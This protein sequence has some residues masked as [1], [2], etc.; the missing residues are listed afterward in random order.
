MPCTSHLPASVVVSTLGPSPSLI[1]CLESLQRQKCEATEIL[2]VVS[3]EDDVESLRS[4]EPFSIR[5]LCEKR[6]GLGVAR[7]RGIRHARGDFVVFI[8]DDARADPDWLHEMISPFSDT[9]VACVTGSVTPCWANYEPSEAEKSYYL[10][11]RARS[12]WVLDPSDAQWFSKAFGK[13]VGYGCNLAFRKNFL[14]NYKR[15]PEEMGV[16]SAIGG[17]EEFYM[18]VQVLKLGFRIAHN[19]NARVTHFFEKDRQ[20]QKLHLRALYTASVAFTL[21]LMLEEPGLRWSL[22]KQVARAVRRRLS[23]KDGPGPEHPL[24]SPLE[25]FAAYLQGFPTFIRSRRHRSKEQAL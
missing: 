9:R 14:L 17:T 18:F 8:D 13:G 2:V 1:R 3:H 21:K 19:P 25:R 24:L 15:F 20:S 10:N 22:L 4:L 5:L 12:S 16:G 23:D 7:N 11:D 6:P